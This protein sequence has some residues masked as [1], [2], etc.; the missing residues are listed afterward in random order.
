MK[1]F[2]KGDTEELLKEK[3]EDNL[4]SRRNEGEIEEKG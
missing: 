4:R 2:L 3:K 1:M